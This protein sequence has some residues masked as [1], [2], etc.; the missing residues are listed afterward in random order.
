M[1]VNDRGGIY[2]CNIFMQVCMWLRTYE[3]YS[4]MSVLQTYMY[5]TYIIAYL[6]AHA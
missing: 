5:D 4:R 1:Y 2:V 3:I 6:T